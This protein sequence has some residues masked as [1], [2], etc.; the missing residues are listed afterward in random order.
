MTVPGAHLLTADELAVIHNAGFG[1]QRVLGAS[2]ALVVVDL[3]RNYVGDDLPIVEQQAR[4]PAGG[5]ALAWDVV[6]ATARLIATARAAGVPIVY[7]RNV[8]KRTTRCDLGAQKEGWDHDQTLEGQPGTE[9]VDQVR[10]EAGDVVVDK[11]YASAFWGTPLSTY[12]VQMKV[13]SLVLTGVS[14]SGCVRATAVDSAMHGFATA[15][16]SDA[17]ADRIQLS[18]HATL[19]DLWMKYADLMTA[20]EAAAYLSA[21]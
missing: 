21:R 6:R 7:T 19:L 4:W 16:V 13:D 8:Q 10:P 3:Q 2:P 15:V 14:T 12:L 11:S 9:I 1:R 18:H 5:G 17:V 20:E